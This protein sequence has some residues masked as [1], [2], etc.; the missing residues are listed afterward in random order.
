VVIAML[1]AGFSTLARAVP[2]AS[3]ANAVYVTGSTAAKPLLAELGRVLVGQDPPVSIVYQG[4][5]SCNGVD[6]ILNGTPVLGAGTTAFSYWDRGGVELKCDAPDGGVVADI[7]LSDVF[8]STCFDLPIGLPATVAD[9]LG[10]VNT[11]TFVVPR[12]STEK[13]ISAEAAYYVYGFGNA[14]GVEPWTD[15]TAIF[16]RDDSSGT[17]RMIA[18]AIGV[19]SRRWKGT[20]TASSTDMITQLNNAATGARAIGILSTDVAQEN[21]STLKILAYQHVGQTCAFFPD[22]DATSNEKINVRDGHYAIWG[23]LHLLTRLDGRG[24]PVSPLAADL[25]GYLT[26]TKAPPVGVD[27]IQLAA[28]QHVIPTCAMRVK[29]V[30]EVGPLA[31]VAP[32]GSCGCYYE[33][34]ANG[35]TTC[36][37]CSS[38]ADCPSTAPAC[39]FGYCE[40]Q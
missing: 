32:V 30:R 31:S 29:R 21:R 38:A 3:I 9:Y 12:S 14:S 23:P 39:N 11:M 27:M 35:A 15:E 34:L 37:A 17:Q 24:A 6:A 16:K 25:I 28:Q 2:C 7:G 4:Q 22:R 18:G 8:A 33:K 19:D 13:A 10:P 1:L 26:G 40:T 5:G 20:L 36:A